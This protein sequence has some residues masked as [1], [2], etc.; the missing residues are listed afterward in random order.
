MGPIVPRRITDAPGPARVL[1]GRPQLLQLCQ[2][3]F[4]SALSSRMRWRRSH[5]GALMPP[6]RLCWTGL[7]SV[8]KTRLPSPRDVRTRQAQVAP[9]CRISARRSD[10]GLDGPLKIRHP[11]GAG[12]RGD[13]GVQQVP[14]PKISSNLKTLLSYAGTGWGT[15]IRTKTNRVRVCCATVTPFPNGIVEQIQRP[16]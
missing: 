8:A 11:L 12:V 2:R 7:S 4:R 13:V 14:S 10:R 1:L 6:S 9:L 5:E 16:A 15:W 3:A